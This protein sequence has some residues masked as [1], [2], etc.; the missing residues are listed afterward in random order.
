M[1]P[2]GKYAASL[3]GTPPPNVAVQAKRKVVRTTPNR[4]SVHW[5][6]QATPVRKYRSAKLAAQP[7]L[8]AATVARRAK[9]G[10]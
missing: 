10:Y 3:P 9:Y 7:T 5:A 4:A 2:T 1:R 8:D 6:K